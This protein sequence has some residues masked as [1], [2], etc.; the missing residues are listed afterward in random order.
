MA[1]S[2][3]IIG[4]VPGGNC[5][6]RRVG[7]ERRHGRLG[8]RPDNESRAQKPIIGAAAAK[9]A[10]EQIVVEGARSRLASKHESAGRGCPAIDRTHHL[11][12]IAEGFCA[13]TSGVVDHKARHA[14]RRAAVDDKLVRRRTVA[15]Q[16]GVHRDRSA[17]SRVAGRRQD[18]ARRSARAHVHQAGIG[19]AWDGLTE[20]IE[21]ER[22]AARDRHCRI[23]AERVRRACSQRARVDI[24]RSAVAVGTCQRGG[25]REHIDSTVAADRGRKHVV[26]GRVIEVDR[27]GASA[28]YDARRSERAGCSRRIARARADVE[29]SN[30]TGVVRDHNRPG[31]KA[32]VRNRERARA[33][34]AN[35]HPRTVAP[36]GARAGHR[37]RTLRA[38]T[39]ADVGGE[40][41]ILMTVPPFAIVS[42]P[43]PKLPILSPPLGP[44][45]QLEPGPVT[46]T[47]PV[48]PAD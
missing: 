31:D 21:I 43:V 18:R 47:V 14:G 33:R 15:P 19:D 1:S 24:R 36:S 42:V 20:A 35:V 4:Q 3:P 48:E 37:H 39:I 22:S 26:G 45:V 8:P 32:A 41:V 12:A 23:R 17:S 6:R 7:R 40:G 13:W 9:A 38:C 25:A 2:G 29:C 11:N 46:V 30:R 16:K 28:K 34:V 27:T 5:A 10:A 44:L